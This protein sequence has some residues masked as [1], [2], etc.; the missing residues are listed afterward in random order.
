MKSLPKISIVIPSYNKVKY[1]QKTLESI[2][3]QNYTNLEV[4][5][6][7]GTSTDGTLEIIKK[8]AIKHPK[9]INWVSIKD[10]GQLDAINKGLKK[11]KGDIV[12][13]INA[14]DM[15]EER[16]LKA[17]ADCYFENLDALWFVGRGSVI[18]EKGKGIA[19]PITAYKNFLLSL[20]SYTCLLSTNYLMQPSIFL[21]KRAYKKY[22]PFTGT[23]DFVMEYDLWLKIGKEKMPVVIN[24]NL[25]K[26][27][28]EPST[29][30]KILF[31]DLLKQDELIVNKYTKNKII[32]FFHKFHNIL[33]V[34]IGRWFV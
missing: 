5:I 21:T 30:T 33:R 17:V 22:G 15:Y 27:R 8:Y 34:I 1:I 2:V 9:I 32:L 14:D 13:Y 20:S 28:I 11:A 12:T 7:D 18:D 25:A 31:A 26:F 3:S 24:K 19:K 10:K 4:I 29:K 23:D 6:Q 16:C